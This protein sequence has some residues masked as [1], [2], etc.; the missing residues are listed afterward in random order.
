MSKPD[1]NTVLAMSI[2]TCVAARDG[3]QTQLELDS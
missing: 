3:N 1:R 2:T